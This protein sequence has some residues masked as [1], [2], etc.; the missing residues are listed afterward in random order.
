MRV[1]EFKNRDNM[2]FIFKERP[3]GQYDLGI[4]TCSS[5]EPDW[6]MMDRLQS[7][8]HLKFDKTYEI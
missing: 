3:D 6:E 8:G 7:K 2:T 5:V 4:V 1:W